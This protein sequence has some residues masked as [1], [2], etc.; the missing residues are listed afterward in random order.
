MDRE[1][2]EG[3]VEVGGEEGEVDG[4]DD[5]VFEVPDGG[6]GEG[7]EEVGVWDY[8]ALRS[9]ADDREMLELG[10]L[11]VVERG[12]LV[13]VLEIILISPIREQFEEVVERRVLWV[14]AELSNIRHLQQ[15]RKH[16]HPRCARRVLHQ[17]RRA[18]AFHRF[19]H[20]EEGLQFSRLRVSDLHL[21]VDD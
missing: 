6:G 2:L 1:G 5:E 14:L 10:D 12:E 13:L 9:H 3:V 18:R 4:V 21:A 7:G 8:A 16:E 17:L 20:Q 19:R 15:L 11:R